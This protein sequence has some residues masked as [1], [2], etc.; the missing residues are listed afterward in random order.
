MEDTLRIAVIDSHTG[1][2]PTRVVVD[3]LPDLGSGSVS[4]QAKRFA[5][6][7][8]WYRSAVVCEPRGSDVLVGAL[9]VE[10][11]EPDAH[12]GVIFF[13]NVGILGMCGHGTI[14]LME[15]LRHMGKVHEGEV[16]IETPVG[17]VTASFEDGWVRVEN[18]ESYRF[19]TGV[20][21]EADGLGRV[22][23]DVAYGG[24]WFYLCTDHGLDLQLANVEELTRAS[25]AIRRGLESA[26]VTGESGAEIDHIELVGAAHGD[27]GGR[28]GGRNFVLCPGGAYDRS[29]CGTGTSAKLACLASDRK[30][31]PGEPW[32]QES[33]CGSVFVGSY[34]PLGRGVKPTIRG[35]AWITGESTL[36]LNP[37][38]PFR[39][40]LVGEV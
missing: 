29:P 24:N 21:V 38:D 1:G 36:W 33:V 40:G 39:F 10:P 27:L 2:E 28:K 20:S 30:L 3:G 15:T 13:N 31:E 23:G 26:G 6:D 37:Q 12:F 18:V 25:W 19:L 11:T 8:D 4:Q 7:Y 22:T 16:V 9:L 5:D 14:G 17:L 34:E 35:Q 32:I